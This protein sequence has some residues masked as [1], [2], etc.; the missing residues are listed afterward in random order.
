MKRS[1]IRELLKL[2]A[3]PGMIS[4]AGGLPAPETFPVE[5]LR[6][7]ADKVLTTLGSQSLQYSESEGIAPLRD[8]IAASHSRP[9]Y[10]VR[11]E[12][13]AVVNGSQQAL[14]LLGRVLL[15]ENDT[16][17]VENPTY[18]ALLSAWRPLGVRFSAIPCEAD[19]L[20]VEDL[21]A[22]LQANPKLAYSIPNYQNPQGSLMSLPRRR[23]LAAL[24]REYGQ[25]LVEDNPYGDLRYEG[26]PLPDVFELNARN[27]DA[28]VLETEVIRTGTF[29]KVLAPGLR[30]GYVVAHPSVIDKIVLA[31]QSTD[32]HTASFN[33]YL[34]LELLQSGLLKSQIPKIRDFYRLRR[35]AML[36]AMAR[37]FPDVVQWT[38]PQGGMFLLATLPHG[39]N[40]SDILSTALAQKVAFVPGADFHLDGRGEN[41]MRLNF[42]YNTPEIIEEGIRRLGQVLHHALAQCPRQPAQPVTTAIFSASGGKLTKSSEASALRR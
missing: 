28:G 6:A 3:Q 18:L 13:V 11:R 7:A 26:E 35:D 15:D 20:R 31:K 21:P 41:T 1:A 9:G 42:S 19:G 30:L 33:Q 27:G 24:L 37:Y 32:L 25:P 29:S 34:V 23:R 38:H 5:P 40:T 8:Y 12:N 10:T 39:A 36:A 17:L 14:D 2:I 16:V 22:L 4:F